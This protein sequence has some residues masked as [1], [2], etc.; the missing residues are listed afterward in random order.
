MNGA[1]RDPFAVDEDWWLEKLTRDWGALYLISFS[2][3]RWY[4][5]RRDGTAAALIAPT[6]GKLATQMATAIR[7]SPREELALE[8]L[9]GQWAGLFAV[10]YEGGIYTAKRPAD[11]LPLTA[12]TLEDLSRAMRSAF[13]HRITK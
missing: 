3:D 8:G 4:G 6:P 7:L 5:I 9:A 11:E 12:R 10:G 1:T 2:N 13:Y